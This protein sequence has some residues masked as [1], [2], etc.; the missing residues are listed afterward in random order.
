MSIVLVYAQRTTIVRLYRALFGNVTSY[1]V[2]HLVSALF[3]V[4]NLRY[5][6]ESLPDIVFVWYARLIRFAFK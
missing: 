4:H 1:A 5:S 2:G 6:N 3:K